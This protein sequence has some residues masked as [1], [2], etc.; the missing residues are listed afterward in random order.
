MAEVV[1]TAP[2]FDVILSSEVR[3]ANKSVAVL[4]G[5]ADKRNLVLSSVHR[6]FRH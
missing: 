1:N 2:T 3:P 5:T 6:L 4:M